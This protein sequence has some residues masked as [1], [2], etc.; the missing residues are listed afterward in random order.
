MIA[1]VV[2]SNASNVAEVTCVISRREDRAREAEV[3]PS[4]AYVCRHTCDITDM[5]V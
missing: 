4:C 1:S 5:G 2:L 3:N